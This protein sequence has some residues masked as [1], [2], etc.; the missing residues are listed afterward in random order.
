M[1]PTSDYPNVTQ[2]LSRYLATGYLRLQK[3]R[4]FDI[5]ARNRLDKHAQRSDESISVNAQPPH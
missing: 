2:E 4:H 3:T 1:K 5:S